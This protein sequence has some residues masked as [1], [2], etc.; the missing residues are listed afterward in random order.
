M[1][2]ECEELK[3]YISFPCCPS[4]KKMV[5]ASGRGRVSDKCPGCGKFAVFD[6]DEM[7]A[8]PAK[9]LRGMV[10]KFNNSVYRP[11]R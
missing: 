6:L 10:S 1:A 8:E 11:S 9:A 2:M 4:Q 7:K 5:Y 3:G